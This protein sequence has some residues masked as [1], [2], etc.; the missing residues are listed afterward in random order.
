M[1]YHY[2]KTR[3]EE[4]PTQDQQ[5]RCLVGFVIRG[6]NDDGS[7]GGITVLNGDGGISGDGAC[8]ALGAEVLEMMVGSLEVTGPAELLAVEGSGHGLED[9]ERTRRSLRDAGGIEEGAGGCRSSVSERFTVNGKGIG[10]WFFPSFNIIEGWFGGS[11]TGT[12]FCRV[13]GRG[14]ERDA[15]GTTG[16][17][18]VEEAGRRP[19]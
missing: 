15:T 9:C 7:I 11:L 8:W 19:T 5:E 16:T 12:F 18:E 4:R 13:A 17:T 3:D 1:F 10:E 14:V 6:D 2:R